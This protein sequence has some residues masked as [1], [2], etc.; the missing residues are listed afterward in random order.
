MAIEIT[1]EKKNE[2]LNSFIDNKD[3]YKTSELGNVRKVIVENYY[4]DYDLF[5]KISK[6]SK[7]RTLLSSVSLLHKIITE[8]IGGRY[9]FRNEEILVDI[10]FIVKN[11]NK[12]QDTYFNKSLL[13]VSLDFL[14][15]LIALIDSDIIKK[16][17]VDDFEKEIN[18][19]YTLYKRII[20]K[21]DLE[22]KDEN[23]FQNIFT[24]VKTYFQHNNYQYSRIWFKFYFLFYYNSKGNSARKTDVINTISTSYIRDSNDP[25]ELKKIISETIDF[26]EFIALEANFLTEMFNLSKTKPL[27][28]IEFYAEF[29][30][31]K[32][33]KIIEFYIP[34]NQNKAIPSL[35]QVLEGIEYNIPNKLNFSNKILNA[36]K[37]LTVHTERQE[38]YNI[39]FSSKL[40]EEI[41]NSSDYSNQIVGLICNNNAH[42]HQL[43]V[44]Q[45]NENGDYIDKKK[46]KD[47]AIPFLMSI[48]TNLAAYGQFFINI[49]NLRIGID[50]R[51]FDSELKNSASYL[52]YIN[53]YIVSSGN[54]N[55][56]NAIVSKVKDETILNIN[57]HFI[58]S[59]NYHNKYNG[60][61]KIIFENK[62]HLSDDLYDKLSQLISNIS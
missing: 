37:T 50:K 8:I 46:L 19:L 44:T 2:I 59:I 27:F 52:A 42:L 22:Q 12:H 4:N 10:L 25:K 60:I 39:L 21:I 15:F 24:K 9:E 31:S 47:K 1:E 14:D 53:N 28:A 56:Y 49:L 26:K 5:D 23:K 20:E 13:I 45:F 48:I 6:S 30:D 38:L 58:R 40:E 51:Y 11:I 41:V 55:F 16:N 29:D 57:N 3:F 17:K 34:V 33:Q 43:G 7:T 36:T 32:K 61:L 62:N 18:E 35:K 54:V